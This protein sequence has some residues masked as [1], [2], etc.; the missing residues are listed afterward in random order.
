MTPAVALP[1]VDAANALSPNR[2]LKQFVNIN[3]FVSVLI[4][5]NLDVLGLLVAI[6]SWMMGFVSLCDLL[7]DP[8][9]LHFDFV[10][11]VFVHGV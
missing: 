3:I 11:D 10:D 1:V 6:F 9:R 2:S 7:D 5:G 4:L 8:G